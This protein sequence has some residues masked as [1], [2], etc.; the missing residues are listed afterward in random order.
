MNT[1]PHQTYQGVIAMSDTPESVRE[2][3]TGLYWADAK[4]S[5]VRAAIEALE[6]YAELLGH[7]VDVVD[8]PDE[9]DHIITLS[10][11]I[12]THDAEIA[13]LKAAL[14]DM[15]SGW[16]YIRQVHGDLYGVGW[17]R[18]QSKAEEALR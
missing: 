15:L 2:V 13:A 3:V 11:L 17:D 1:H 8:Y 12:A 16:R 9:T 10:E 6:R 5:E 14:S 7:V 18:A 4:L